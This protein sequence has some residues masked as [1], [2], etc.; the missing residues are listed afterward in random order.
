MYHDDVEVSACLKVRTDDIR[1][2]GGWQL[3][4][5]RSTLLRAPPG[6]EGI[7]YAR[8]RLPLSMKALGYM[9]RIRNVRARVISEYLVSSRQQV[10]PD[11][12]FL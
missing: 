3:D 11:A 12:L 8:K 1:K 5:V 6:Y 4:S 2:Q 9:F 7:V 10:Q